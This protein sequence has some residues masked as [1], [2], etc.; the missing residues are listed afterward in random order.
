V[1]GLWQRFRSWW[2]ADALAKAEEETRMTRLERDVSEEDY[3][4][5]K[6]DEFVT[7]DLFAGGV[8]DYEGDSER[9][10][11]PTP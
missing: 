1:P 7:R 11:D 10:R 5:H 3:E 2:N 9:P 8:D 6:D 4:G